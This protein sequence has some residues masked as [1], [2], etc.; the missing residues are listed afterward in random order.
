M[1]ALAK[2]AKRVASQLELFNIHCND[3]EAAV[4]HQKVEFASAD[5]S[6]SGFD[7][8]R[9][10]QNGRGRHQPDRIS[11]DQGFLVRG[12]RLVTQQGDDD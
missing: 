6:V 11:F 5:V 4:K 12:L 2:T 9:G 3:V 7:D 1:P 8:D 10:F